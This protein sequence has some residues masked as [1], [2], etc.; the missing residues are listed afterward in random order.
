MVWV[1]AAAA[2]GAVAAVWDKAAAGAVVWAEAD[3]VDPTS[4]EAGTGPNLAV[5]SCVGHDSPFFRHPQAPVT[6]LVTKD[7]VMGHNPVPALCTN[8]SFRRRLRN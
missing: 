7:R 4:T 3:K 1:E 8:H 2:V 5:G 6:V